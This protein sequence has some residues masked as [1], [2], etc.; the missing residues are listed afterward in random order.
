M[1]RSY[2]SGAVA[3]RWEGNWTSSSSL[4]PS[5][6]K[7]TV[8]LNLS[9]LLSGGNENGPVVR[10]C[11]RKAGNETRPVFWPLAL[12]REGNWASSSASVA[13]R[14]EGAWTS[15]SASVTIS[16]ARNR[17]NS[18]AIIVVSYGWTLSEWGELSSI[19]ETI[20]VAHAAQQVV[21]SEGKGLF[22]ARPPTNA[23]CGCVACSKYTWRTSKREH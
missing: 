9:P 6:G 13:I 8:P 12:R 3:V 20:I 14:W 11:C 15:R 18:G 7:E 17:S 4:L 19:F 5:V 23:S 10:L 2:S 1:N 22:W 16:R 21:A